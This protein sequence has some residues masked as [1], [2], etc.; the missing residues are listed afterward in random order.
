[1]TIPSF[2]TAIRTTYQAAFSRYG[3]SEQAVLWGAGRQ[4]LRFAALT[5]HLPDG[6]FSVLDFGCGL[7]DL[8]LW[9]RLH[10]P[11][12]RYRGVDIVPEFID[13]NR[14]HMP[15]IPFDLIESPDDIGEPV[16]FVISCGTFNLRCTPSVMEHRDWVHNTIGTISGLARFSLSLDFLSTNVDYM[17]LQSYHQDPFDIIEFISS[18][19]SPRIIYDYS[20]L[21]YEYCVTAMADSVIQRPSNTYRAFPDGG[22]HE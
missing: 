5:R 16:D 13:S 2:Q 11:G 1:M 12:W 15:K 8:A 22:L 3:R 6:P 9:A 4:D 19:Y 10:R 21:P 17:L 7:G 18:R 20:Y 14:R